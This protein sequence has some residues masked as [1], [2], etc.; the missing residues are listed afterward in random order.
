MTT[1]Q[2]N[3]EFAELYPKLEDYAKKALNHFRS[4]VDLS[5]V[6]SECYLHVRRYETEIQN[7]SQLEAYCKHWMKQNIRWRTSPLSKPYFQAQH[8]ELSDSFIDNSFDL[9]SFID[10]KTRE[11]HSTLS[12]YEQRLWSIYFEKHKDSGRLIAEHLDM[13][14]STGYIVLR[15]CKQL[16]E[17]YREFLLRYI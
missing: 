12:T 16:S 9:G 5:A 14:I 10:V 1:Q 2:L 11:F 17:K 6:L 3:H 7:S 15:E 13:S 8:E 4:P